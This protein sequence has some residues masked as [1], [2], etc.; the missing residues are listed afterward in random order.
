MNSCLTCSEIW[1]YFSYESV[2]RW[3]L[4]GALTILEGL[5][6]CRLRPGELWEKQWLFP[7]AYYPGDGSRQGAC[8]EGN[9]QEKEVTAGVGVRVRVG[10]EW[11]AERNG[12]ILEINFRGRE[13]GSHHGVGDT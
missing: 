3:G 5:N 11:E 13:T 9:S 12:K 2:V 1:F 7:V 8:V 10:K 4:G 6:I